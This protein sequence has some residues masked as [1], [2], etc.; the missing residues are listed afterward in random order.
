MRQILHQSIVCLFVFMLPIEADAAPPG[1]SGGGGRIGGPSGSFG[2][3][4][5]SFGGSSFGNF[6]SPQR[7]F[8]SRSQSRSSYQ[9]GSPS[10]ES[11]ARGGDAFEQRRL[12]EERILNH[13]LDQAEHLRQ[14]SASN[15]NAHLAETADGMERNAQ[16]HF[17]DHGQRIDSFQNRV[18]TQNGPPYMPQHP[19]VRQPRTAPPNPPA[20]AKKPS[21][22][23][24]MKGLWP[25]K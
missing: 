12:N 25:F 10:L 1:R 2:S 21:L 4:N 11:R 24:R 19:A 14:Q 20:V 13:R 8:G 23:D 22:L 16:Q 5:R 9:T 6:P 17:A 15:G 18:S 3:A 7:D